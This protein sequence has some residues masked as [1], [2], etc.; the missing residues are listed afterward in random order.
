MTPAPSMFC[1]QPFGS[2]RA[3]GITLVEFAI[4]F[5]LAT[6]F[7]LSLIQ[8]GM[9]Y[10]AK[11]TLNHATFMA[12]REGSLH[13]ASESSI[14]EALVRGLIPFY[15][16]N[17][18][19][20]D[21][22]RLAAAYATSL[23]ANKSLNPYAAEIEILSP[24]SD[25]FTDFGVK[26]ATTKVTYIPNDNLEY[27]D[28]GQVGA[29]SK[30]NIRDANLL[31]IRVR[32]G[33]ELK[34]PLIGGVMKRMMCGGSIGV[35]AYGNVKPWSALL[36]ATQPEDCLKYYQRP[37]SGDRVYMPIESFAIVEM[38]SRAEQIH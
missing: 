28:L 8:V 33:Y 21:T 25:T 18:Q 26:D 15:Q 13:N 29:K 9:V 32:Y 27:R 11:L 35:D 6:L 3:R 4:V 31:K 24:S 16:D 17:T 10:M 7:V 38:Q 30:Q 22:T 2:S 12:A 5:P 1:R 19:T 34:V 36:L 23:L 14:R 37:L 20:N